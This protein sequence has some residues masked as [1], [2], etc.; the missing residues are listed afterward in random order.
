[1]HAPIPKHIPLS[2]FK[3]NLKFKVHKYVSHRHRTEA[4]VKLPDMM[5]GTLQGMN[6]MANA[7]D[8]LQLYKEEDKACAATLIPSLDI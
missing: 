7:I 5:K 3:L 4:G 8:K 1:M 6:N 2:L